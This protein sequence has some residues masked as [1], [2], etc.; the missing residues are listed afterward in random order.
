MTVS[1][2]ARHPRAWQRL[3]PAAVAVAGWAID[4]VFPPVCWHC[5]RP[6]VRSCADCQRRLDAVAVR[7]LPRQV[8]QLETVYATGAHD[9]A[10]KSAVQAFKYAG[11]TEL[12]GSLA[13]R[14]IHALAQVNLPVDT[15]VPVPLHARK[16]AERGYNQAKL[17]CNVLAAELDMP[18]EPGWL[19]RV[20]NTRQQAQLTSAERESTVKG[21]FEAVGDA[22]GRAFLLVDDV[23]TT[24]ATLSDCARALRNAGAAAVFGIVVSMPQST[25][26]NAGR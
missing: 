23:V 4:L 14:L 10:L 8:D 6:D 9:G 25:A 26:K 20:R 12:A 3:K 24:G 18:C 1:Q 11:A 7:C 21:A 13:Q 17:L 19:Q 16:Q 5:G 15:I 2:T 22:S